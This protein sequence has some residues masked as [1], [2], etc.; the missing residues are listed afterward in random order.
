ML[1]IISDLLHEHR[2]NIA[3]RGR[4]LLL[5]KMFDK[6]RVENNEL[7]QKIENNRPVLVPGKS[8][9]TKYRIAQFV[10]Y[11]GAKF[12]RKSSGGFEKTAFCP[13]CDYPLSSLNRLF[14]LRCRKC[15]FDTSFCHDELRGILIKVEKEFAK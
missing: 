1:R 14:P 11:S 4:L 10:R 3:L 5:D 9:E 12:K 8:V 13:L 7:K 15:N 2:S 6:M